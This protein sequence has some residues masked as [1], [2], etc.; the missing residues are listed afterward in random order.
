MPFGKNWGLVCVSFLSHFRVSSLV[1]STFLEQE[2]KLRTLA[3][4]LHCE[5]TGFL[6]ET[7]RNDEGEEETFRNDP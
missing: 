5:N 6:I 3:K 4:N 7:F 2:S 1:V